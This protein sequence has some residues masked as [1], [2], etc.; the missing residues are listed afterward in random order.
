MVWLGLMILNGKSN[1][2]GTTK[3][4]IA[5]LGYSSDIQNYWQEGKAWANSYFLQYLLS[6]ITEIILFIFLNFT[7]MYMGPF[8]LFLLNLRWVLPV[9]NS[10]LS[11]DNVSPYL[12]FFVF[13]PGILLDGCWTLWIDPT[14][15]QLFP[16][17]FHPFCITFGTISSI[18]S[19]S[20]STETFTFKSSGCPCLSTHIYMHMCTG[21]IYGPHSM[22]P[23]KVKAK[24]SFLK[25]N[26]V[27]PKRTRVTL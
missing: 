16:H 22:P 17:N 13:P 5:S 14:F 10:Y 9:Q 4:S 6:E 15:F 27:L 11:F 18:L 12:H 24:K 25:G 26:F 19:S 1:S 8:L 7:T 20:P 3:T 23:L 21:R 2:L